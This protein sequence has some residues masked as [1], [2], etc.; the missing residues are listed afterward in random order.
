METMATT[1]KSTTSKKKLDELL[2]ISD[3]SSVD[4]FLN[5]LTVE[6]DSAEEA[7][8]K[9]NDDVKHE[10]EKIDAKIAN[11]GN[12][13]DREKLMS[14]I[15][16]KSSLGSIDELIEIS[17]NVIKHVYENIVCTELVDSE[18]IHAAAAFIESCRLNIHEYIEIYKDRAKFLNKVEFEM[19]QQ[20][21]RIELLDKKFELDMKKNESK[22]ID[23][24]PDNMK[25]F[26]QEDV[27]KALKDLQ[28]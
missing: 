27:V 21:H 4:D 7:I 22:A 13:D 10:V 2:G 9:I 25:A 23:I 5:N 28:L 6:N 18:L 15:D 24:V 11:F 12:A 17:K 14:L 20:K 16:I 8:S 3:G 19:L 26:N 1:N